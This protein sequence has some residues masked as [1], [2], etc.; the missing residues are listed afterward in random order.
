MRDEQAPVPANERSPTP[1]P[2]TQGTSGTDERYRGLFTGCPVA[3][4]EEDIT[5]L[6]ARLDQLR[7]AGV[8]D[9]RAHLTAHPEEVARCAALIRVVAVNQATLALYGAPDEQSLLAG[10]G[11]VFTEESFATFREIV[12][13]FA[14]GKRQFEAEAVNRTLQGAVLHVNQRWS[15]LPDQNGNLTRVLLSVT[16][17]TDRTRDHQ[18]L[19]KSEEGLARAQQIAHVGDWEWELATNE[20]RWSDELFRIYGFEPR[21]VKPDYGLVLAQMHPATKEQFLKAI[22]AA[23]HEDRPF[24]MDY[25]FFRRDGSEAALHTIG[26]VVRDGAGAPARMIGI[27]QDI[28]ERRNAETRIR[29]SED[30]F[31]SIFEYATDG[32]MI[33][34]PEQKTIV[35]VNS[36][37]CAMLGA[38]RDELVGHPIAALH[39][40][41]DFPRVLETFERQL[42]GEITLAPDIPM[43]RKDGSVFAAAVNSRMVTLGGKPFLLGSFRDITEQK[44]AEERITRSEEFVR[45]ILDTVDEGFIVV[46]R[47]YR[48]ITANRAYGAQAGINGES[49]VGRHCHE[50]SHRLPRPCFEQG[51]ECAVRRVFETGEPA[52][53][54]HRHLGPAGATLYVETRAFPLTN[55][56][57]RVISAIETVTNITEKH[58][59]EEE[60]LKS[61]KLESIGTLAGGI[62]HD[63]NNLLQGVFGYISMA[64]MSIENRERSLAMLEQA[65]KALHLSVN[66]TAQLLTFSKGGKPVK[67]RIALSP[68]IEN[69]ARFAMSGSRSECRLR[70]A[71]ELW[72]ADADEG[73]IGQVIQNIVLNADQ[74]MPLGGQITIAARNL[75]ANEAFAQHGLPREDFVEIAIEDQ[76]VGIPAQY[77]DKIFD[78][79]FTT[80]EKGSGLGLAT[81]YSIVRNHGGRIE[82][83]STPGEG[84]A[85]VIFLPAVNARPEKRADRETAA[86]PGAARILFM[87]D[88]EIVLRVAVEMLRLL[89]HE[90]ESAERGEEAIEKFLAARAAGKPFDLVILDLTI[91]GGLGGAETMRR[92]LEIDPGVKAVVTSG[93]SD[94]AVTAS[95][96]EHGFCSILKKPFHFEELRRTVGA[97]LA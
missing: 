93:Y 14:E 84:S 23:L 39:P 46:D 12:I 8:G 33:A 57:G 4:W 69:A 30:R 64:K 17:L 61:Q 1:P 27:V 40:T 87:D 38:T 5:A 13:A 36:A 41:D 20:V 49:V 51:E 70:L 9:L 35:E 56:D 79:Y 25:Q 62:A 43:L 11:S 48:I 16:D 10:L 77:L 68:V 63:F 34:D 88:E 67:Q 42:R 89:G 82:A 78:P 66:L 47:D 29:E 97:Q 24:E 85:F 19:R 54:L 59:L 86:S 26:R 3:L 52:T 60:R 91:R 53:A 28:S 80:K 6:V 44:Q 65:E 90:V 2:A 92:L 22:D 71:P 50:I 15:V 83:R 45:S 37:I 72:Q 73:Q 74:A 95:Y 75:P 76:G 18:A 96:Q 32:I 7:A 94:D 21:S 81:S 58:L 55:T 31:R